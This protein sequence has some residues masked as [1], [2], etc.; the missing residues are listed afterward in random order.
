MRTLLVA[1]LLSCA[2][3]AGCMEQDSSP[4]TT[5]PTTS[6][7]TTTAGNGTLASYSCSITVGLSGNANLD[8]GTGG[9]IFTSATPS[10]GVV[11]ELKPASGCTGWYDTTPG[12]TQTEGTT[13][14]GNDYPEGT[15]FGVYC[16]PTASP[17]AS[18]SMSIV[19][20][21]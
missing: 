12:D 4:T 13:S 14:A 3:L 18:S 11:L 5:A 19:L 20:E 10:A 8:N 16:G 15:A 6:A 7:T 2:L 1:A 17:G 21:S 9:C